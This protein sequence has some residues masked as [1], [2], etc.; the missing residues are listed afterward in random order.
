V[1]GSIAH[2]YPLSSYGLDVRIGFSL[3]KIENNL[4]GALQNVAA[5]SWMGLVYVLKGVLLLLEWAFSLDLLGGALPGVRNGLETLHERVIG[6]P[7]FLAA[8]S[9]AG[10]WG[11]W[12]GLVQRRTIETLG[13]LAATV[14]L[15][16]AA[17]VVIA[18]PAGTVGYASKLANEGSLGLLSAASTGRVKEPARSFSDSMQGLFDSL[19][20]E[21][22]CALEF[23]SVDWCLERAGKGSGVTNADLWLSFPAQS[24]ERKSLYKLTKGENPDGGGILGSGISLGDLAGGALKTV[25]GGP[26]GGALGVVGLGSKALGGRDAGLSDKIKALVQKDPE[27]VK[28][29]EAGGTFPRFALLALVA[30]G[31]LGAIALLLYLGI[32]LLLAGMLALI[33]LLFAPAMLLAPAF[34]ESGRAAFIGW[35]KRLVG[36]LAA[37]LVYALLLALVLVA[38]SAIAAVG[39]GWFATWLLQLAF[40][41][42]ILLKRKELVGFLSVGRAAAIRGTAGGRSLRRDARVASAAI[43]SAGRRAGALGVVPALALAGRGRAR[44]ELGREGVQVAAREELADRSDRALRLQL[45]GARAAL[46]RD[47]TLEQE[48]RDTNRGLTK[49]DTL[50]QAHKEWGKPPPEPSEKEAALLRRRDVL[51]ASKD[52]V[53]ATRQAKSIAGTADRNLA[54]TGREFSDPDRT[55]LLDQRRRD[56]ESGLPFEH[57]RNLRFAGIEPRAYDRASSEQRAELR[58]R[59]REA[60]ERDRRLLSVVPDQGRPEPGRS[61]IRHARIELS[62]ELVRERIR[63]RRQIRRQARRAP[64]RE[65]VYRRR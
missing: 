9:V 35:G 39:I 54:L 29:Q 55:A 16:V 52:P 23:G 10:L 30:A 36:A 7:W 59:S 28:M 48:L 40:W 12:R 56:I 3:T 27:R 31:M 22:W 14:A 62:P 65:R 43:G 51:E 57:G 17:L 21:P 64:Q 41:W 18:N 49:Y 44:S 50:V 60:L 63:E 2:T 53:E 42:G 34:G 33:L 26:L 38:A 37:K 46:A 47:D 5:L 45:E 25:T 6:E 61:H 58:E 13:G 4:L 20:L 32:R 8:I 11:I 19:V 15:M 24:D 1:S